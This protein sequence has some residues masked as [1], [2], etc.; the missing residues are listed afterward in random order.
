[1]KDQNYTRSI[2]IPATASNVFNHINNVSGWWAVNANGQKSEIEGQSAKLNDEFIMR[3][4]DVHYSKQKL[5]E[6]V[7]NKKVVWLV[8]D[9]KLNWLE[10]DKTEWTGTKMIFELSPNGDN[11]VL[12]F[13]HEGLL[14]GKEC[15]NRC[16]P[17]WDMFITERLRNFIVGTIAV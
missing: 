2:E 7:P 4:G 9:S 17:S 6:V 5:V 8:T 11:T 16:A 13:T 1:M 12:T 15:Y 14:P 10:N 3:F